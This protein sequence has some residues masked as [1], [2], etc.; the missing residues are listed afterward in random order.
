[1]GEP[2]IVTVKP[3]GSI[4]IE[5]D[6]VILDAQGNRFTPP[7]GKQPG[8]VKLCGCGRTGDWPFCDGSHKKD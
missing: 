6:V 4:R 7:A 2:I 8:V 5:G 3:K 1:M